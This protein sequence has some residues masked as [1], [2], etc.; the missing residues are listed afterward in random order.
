MIWKIE[1][2]QAVEKELKKLDRQIQL[3][4]FSFLKE[5]IAPAKEPYIYG[6]SL[7]NKFT[8]LYRFRVGDY[9]I[10]CQIDDKQSSILV[11]RVRHRR[12]AYR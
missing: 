11:I 8:G 12:N 5:K 4:I 7:K 1:F 6:E 2:H 10:L 3:R 9:R